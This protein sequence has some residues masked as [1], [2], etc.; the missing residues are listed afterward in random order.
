MIRSALPV[1]EAL[2]ALRQ[3]LA[4]HSAA[5]LQAPPGAGKTTQVPLALLHESWLG[6]RSILM[7]EPRR[8]AARAACARMAQL[9]DESPGQ[10]VGYRIRFDSKVSAQTRIEVL[11]EGIL[12]R[13]LQTDPELKNVGLVIFDE[14]HERHLHAD[15]A[16]ALCLDSQ[17]VL[18]DDLKILIMSATLDSKA[19]AQ[20][21]DDS[22]VVSSF[23]RSYPV[24][25]RYLTRDFEGPLPPLMSETILKALATDS[26]DVLAFLPGAGEIRRTQDLLS[27]RLGPEVDVF[28]LYGDLSWE[29]QDRA[30]RPTPGRR[31]IVLATPIAETSLTIEGV[32]VVVDSGYARVPQFSPQSGLSRLTTQRISRASSEQRA[33]RAGR[34]APGVC[35][36]LWSETTQRGLVPYATPEIRSVDLAPLA[37]ELAA[38]GVV[39]AQTLRWLD[40][41]PASAFNQA[42]ELLIE[43]DA[44]DAAGH[45]TDTGRAMLRLPLHPR[46]SHMLYAAERMGLGALACDIAALISERDIFLGASRRSADFSQRLEALWALRAHARHSERQGV[47]AAACARVQQAA[48][49]FQR[50]LASPAQMKT[51]DIKHVG[52]LLALAYPDR[53]AQARAPGDMRYLLAS[54]RGARLPEFEIGLRQPYIVAASLDAGETEGLIYLA[55]VINE[56]DLHQH[57]PSHVHSEESVYWDTQQQQV[58]AC[59]EERFAA[60]VLDRKPLK[61]ADPEKIRRAMLDGVRRLGIDVLPWTREAREWQARVLSLRHWLADEAWPDVSDGAL[62]A[63]LEDWLGPYLDGIMRR[64]HLARLDLPTILKSQLDWEMNRRLDEGAPTHLTV[65]SGSQRQLEYHPGESPVLK[66]KLQE[67]FGQADTPRVAWGRVPVTLHL[68]SPAQRPIQVTQDLRGFWERTYSEVKKELKGR[69]PRHPWPDDPWNAPP[70]ARAARRSHR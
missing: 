21:L 35:Y 23:G 62:L 20:L 11:T 27:A 37:L 22:P 60:L 2:P 49:Q 9:L 43:L 26:G 40:P 8:L 33:G 42:R 15:L 6:S 5:V 12:T 55:A 25:L 57:L 39:D 3:A 53:V 66:V 1:D 70:T 51:Q 48:Q 45:I 19:I 38:W 56:D 24:E 46:L 29:A 34:M 14:F 64:D 41:P 17:K 18:R 10:T 52:L 32:R 16:L 54:G 47:D 68:L 58:I 7:L 31:K 69:Y 28:P 59:R 50:L 36:R 63:T 4:T 61:Q 13:R 30:L 67:M 65:P 44:V